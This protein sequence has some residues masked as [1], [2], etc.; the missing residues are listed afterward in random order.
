MHCSD[1]DQDCSKLFYRAP[2][3]SDVPDRLN[4]VPKCRDCGAP[5]KPHCMFF[6]ECYNEH[7]YRDKTTRAI[8]DDKMD[9]LIVVGTALAT[10][11]AKRMVIQALG[12]HNVPVIEINLE[13]V[14]DEGYT[15]K[16]PMKSEQALEQMFNELYRRDKAA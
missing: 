11:G 5:M 9:A 13:P 4:H 15:L 16:I 8:L 14:I 10:S 12:Q 7:Y 3:L 2:E 6:D 1:E